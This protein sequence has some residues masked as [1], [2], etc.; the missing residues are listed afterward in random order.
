[1]FNSIKKILPIVL[2]FSCLFAVACN[3]KSSGGDGEVVAKVGAKEITLKQVDTVIKQQ[4]EQSPGTTFTPAELAA[5]RLTVLDKLIRDEALFQK[6][7]KENVVPDDGKVTQEFQKRK[8]TLGL[9]EEK[10]QE[11]LKLSGKTEDELKDDVRHELA[12]TALTEKQNTRVNPPS[13]DE[14]KKYYEDHRAEFKAVRG[15]DLSLISVSP[16][17]N[18]GDVGAETK[19][20]AIYAQ[21][22]GGSDFATI[23]AQRSEDPSNVRGGNFGFLSEDQLKQGFPTRPEIVQRLM[24]TMSAGEYTEPLKD[25]LSGSWSIFKLN[26]R[27]DKEENLAF[28][29]PEVRKSIV[30]AITQQRQ[31]V[32]M[33]A[34][35]LISISES[36]P[37]NYLAERIVED[38]K[39]I[40]EMKPSAVLAQAPQTQPQPQPR[41][42]NQ[43]QATPAATNANKP[44]A[45]NAN[46]NSAKPAAANSNK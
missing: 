11:Q 31:Q 24:T 18:G 22:K 40:V 26:Q 4:L 35:L 6:A 38:P 14:V 21:L 34:L 5:A 19:I 28:E 25:N 37:K 33:N 15:V 23:A 13:E 36:S 39:R 3:G 44:A 42:E 7:Q 2:V 10:Y 8:Q 17:N 9:T 32:L 43:N 45:A 30:D 1:V 12:I 27:R 29:N 20:K 41:V 16:A 46:A